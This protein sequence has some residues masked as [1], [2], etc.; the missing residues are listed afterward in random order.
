MVLFLS[1]GDIY[2]LCGHCLDR[3]ADDFHSFA[4][5]M[6]IER[7]TAAANSLNT[8]LKS[9][10]LAGAIPGETNLSKSVFTV[11]SVQNSLLSLACYLK[12]ACYPYLFM[13]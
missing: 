8:S 6:M 1:A 3:Y 7:M 10:A 5:P 11:K 9:K 13:N 12:L 2:I 4:S